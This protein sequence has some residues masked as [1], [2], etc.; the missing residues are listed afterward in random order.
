MDA[1]AVE[2]AIKAFLREMRERLEKA[3]GIAA[4]AEAEVCSVAGN[5][6]KASTSRSTPSS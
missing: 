6:Q 3:A 5:F 4:A 1:Q 2:I